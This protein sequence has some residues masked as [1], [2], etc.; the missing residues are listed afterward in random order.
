[1]TYES[2]SKRLKLEAGHEEVEMVPSSQESAFPLTQPLG[3]SSLAGQYTREATPP[4]ITRPSTPPMTLT[5]L[6]RP[7]QTTPSPSR[8]TF[9]IPTP[10]P[11]VKPEL[12]TPEQ[13]NIPLPPTSHKRGGRFAVDALSPASQRLLA[14]TEPFRGR[15]GPRT[16]GDFPGKRASAEMGG[17][18]GREWDGGKRARLEAILVRA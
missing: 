17:S 3:D 7:A 10:P 5:Q 13:E 14:I 6:Y 15:G 18:G 9:N 4:K 8:R 11:N 2:P 1:M 12:L 16:E